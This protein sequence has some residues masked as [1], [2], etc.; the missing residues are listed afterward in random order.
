MNQER[1][2]EGTVIGTGATINVK[3][4][5]KPRY[6]LVHNYT[7]ANM[8]SVEWWE[9][10]PAAYGLKR[11]DSTFSRLTSLGISQ[12]TGSDEDGGG[13][14][15]SIGADLDVNVNAEVMYWIAIR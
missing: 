11:K 7:S 6:V 15:F 8:E 10:M 13:Q 1:F 2:A 4:G 3:C 5:F 12:Y 9:G 14:G